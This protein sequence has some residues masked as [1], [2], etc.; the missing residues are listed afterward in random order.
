MAKSFRTIRDN[1]SNS[2]DQFEK[3]DQ[4][5]YLVTPLWAI[6]EFSCLKVVVYSLMT[7]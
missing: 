7:A 1:D 2:L 5:K 3:G 4:G 6:S